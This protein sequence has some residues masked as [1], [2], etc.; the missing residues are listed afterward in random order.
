M[1]KPLSTPDRPMSSA[2]LAARFERGARLSAPFV[3]FAVTAVL[4]LVELTYEV[5]FQLGQAVHARSAQL[6]DLHR[7]ALGL[8]APSTPGVPVAE[9]KAVPV[10]HPLADLA[11]CLELLPVRELR[12]I[13]GGNSKKARK[14]DLIA[15]IVAC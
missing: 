11:A 8:T 10:T 2:Q 3:A 1:G 12:P 9:K 14:S 4:L 5:G 6:A 15:S 13:A 7:W